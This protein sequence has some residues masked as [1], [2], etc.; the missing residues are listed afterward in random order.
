MLSLCRFHLNAGTSRPPQVAFTGSTEVGKLVGAAAA[1]GVKPCT[2]ELGGK[3]PVIVCPDVDVGWA[4]KQ[5]HAALFFNAG[6]CCT[7]G[8]RV[9]VH[10]DIY[11]EFVE[12]SAEA[13]RNRWALRGWVCSQAGCKSWK[14]G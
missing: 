5:A 9:F 4:V 8:S 1:K 10:E 11:E 12:K 7:A 13:A 14:L 2:L 3:S 6:Q